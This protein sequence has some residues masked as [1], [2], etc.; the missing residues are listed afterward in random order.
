MS[1]SYARLFEEQ[2]RIADLERQLESARSLAVDRDQRLARI[3][4]HLSRCV[5]FRRGEFDGVNVSESMKHLLPAIQ[6][7]R[8]EE[9]NG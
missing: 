2:A 6:I 4:E 7:A 9:E 5:T 8:G 1:V 3:A